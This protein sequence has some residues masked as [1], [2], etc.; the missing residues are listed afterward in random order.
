M[1]SSAVAP[2]LYHWTA[3]YGTPGLCSEASSSV[4]RRR[5]AASGWL[6]MAHAFGSAIHAALRLPMWR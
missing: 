5:C 4:Q 3:C 6:I 1:T 2:S